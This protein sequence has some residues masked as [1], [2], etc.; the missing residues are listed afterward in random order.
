[1]WMRRK[2]MTEIM[3]LDNDALTPSDYCLMGMHMKFEDYTAQ[4][5]K[6]DIIEYFNEQ[7][8]GQGDNIEYINIGYDIREYYKHSERYDQLIKNQYLVD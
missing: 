1:M 4:G 2:L 8:D 5:M 7:F 6:D 3:E